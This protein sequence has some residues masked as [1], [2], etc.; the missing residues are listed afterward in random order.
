MM[1]VVRGEQILTTLTRPSNRNP[2]IQDPFNV[3][4]VTILR[5]SAF[6]AQPSMSI[7][8]VASVFI[9]SARRNK[10]TRRKNNRGG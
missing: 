2:W 1:I 9:A 6:V 10:D 7:V 4:P 5:S 3:C 8:P